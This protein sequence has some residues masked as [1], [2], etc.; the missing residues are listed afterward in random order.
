M[1]EKKVVKLRVVKSAKRREE[2]KRV[3]DHLGEAAKRGRSDK[4]VGW[5]L[6]TWTEDETAAASWCVDSPLSKLPHVMM[7]GFVHGTIRRELSAD[8][9]AETAAEEQDKTD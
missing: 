8:I 7:P 1:T 6:V 4:I 5:A 9:A 3:A 2:F